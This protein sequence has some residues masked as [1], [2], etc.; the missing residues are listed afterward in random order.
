MGAEKRGT[1]NGGFFH[2]F[3][4]N[5]KSRKKLFASG[6]ASSENILFATNLTPVSSIAFLLAE[7]VRK[8]TNGGDSLQSN[9]I[10]LMEDDDIVGV[11]SVKGSSDYSC[12]SSVTDEEGNGIRAPGVVARLMGLDSLPNAG[13]PEPYSTPLSNSCSIHETYHKKRSLDFRIDDQFSNMGGKSEFYY[14]KP[15]EPKCQR[16]PSS[17]IERFQT[18][19]LP[20]R[21]SKSLP[22]THYLSPIRN[23]R[24]LSGKDAAHIM[25]AAAKILEPGLHVNAKDKVPALNSSSCILRV[26]G[27][28]EDITLSQRSSRLLE[29]S[30]P[31]DSNAIKY[32][33]GH[34]L[35]KS[36]N[37][38]ESTSTRAS[39]QCEG[40]SSTGAKCMEKT[41]SLAIQAKVNV[42]RREGLTTSRNASSPRQQDET[43]QNQPFKNSVSSK[44][45]V[46][47]KSSA[48]GP[49]GVLKQNNQK[50]NC[51]SAKD[52]MTAKTSGSNQQVGKVHVG[53]A[54]SGKHRTLINKAKGS[55]KTGY[56]KEELQATEQDK[57]AFTSRTKDVPRK[58]RLL[59]GNYQSD[60]NDISDPIPVDRHGKC[61]QSS[62]MIDE[63][64]KSEND[65]RRNVVESTDVV[66]FTF[67]SPMIKPLP[68]SHSAYIME[69]HDMSSF[70][71]GLHGKMNDLDASSTKQSSLGL[72]MISGDALSILLE[73]KL[74]EL[75]SGFESDSDL[76]KMGHMSVST[77]SSKSGQTIPMLYEKDTIPET[78]R[79]GPCDESDA[80]LLPNGQSYD[81]SS[82]W[83]GAE[84][85]TE[86]SSSSSEAHKG[87]ERRH[88]SPL[89]ILEASFSNESCNSSDS[90]DSA[91]GSKSC[92]SVQAQHGSGRK[93][94]QSEE[95]TDISDS[96]SSYTDSV[97]GG[98]LRAEIIAV[99]AAD[100]TEICKQE[101]QY[102][103]DILR[104]ADINP[105]A[106]TLCP[107]H[108]A[109][110]P[111]L[112]DQLESKRKTNRSRA[113]GSESN[114]D[115]FGHWR[116]LLFDCVGEC[117]E[118]RR[119]HY[120]QAGYR[121]WAK[122][123][124]T[125]VAN[126]RA[127]A[128]A[129]DV[130]REISDWR[131]MG[132]WMVDELVDKDMSTCL[133][134]WVD[135][136]VEAFEGGVEVEKE[137][138]GSL[139]DEIVADFL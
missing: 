24:F 74:R 37:G 35:N 118:S 50:Q 54:S 107:P 104:T 88:P 38:P 111:L 119:G 8:G 105:E 117:L 90:I 36:W 129:D 68:G 73:Q 139:V 57:D 112:F 75:T 91:N 133:G 84:G 115:Y 70:S 94:P 5:R 72:N 137:I 89:S 93:R 64:Q 55:S 41:I 113:K 9:H 34:S 123:A 60:R 101:S 51:P 136:E 78:H 106:M 135:F 92:S 16:M 102:V 6:N 1:K 69:K 18:E 71:V 32:L 11:S 77:S 121:S 98:H 116:R 66:S 130:Y 58:K 134:R 67:N 110:D 131:S 20:P 125:A 61:F 3:D 132:D 99:A 103:G 40:T 79:T 4:W 45:N 47:K 2:L 97:C 122:G 108:Q 44:K 124:A 63:H 87:S 95:E 48:A 53:D 65:I 25:E 120:F 83:Q 22:I 85:V 56:R 59:Q 21:S 86:C 128:L 43:K 19:V 39:P 80:S 7:G 26:Q 127:D 29:S 31:L 42:Q 76:V 126:R 82:Y 33:K 28:K 109:L 30:R 114:E 138:L 96:A 46:Q 62:I 13:V 17:P 81:L 100:P 23:P 14:R 15:L 10:H 12:A 27:A 49:S 52:K